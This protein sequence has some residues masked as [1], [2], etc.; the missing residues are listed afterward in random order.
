VQLHV[1]RLL[2][3]ARETG[4][5]EEAAVHDVAPV[6]L[7]ELARVEEVN[8][9]RAA[10]LARRRDR[11]RRTGDRRRRRGDGSG[12]RLADCLHGVCSFLGQRLR[13]GGREVLVPVPRGDQLPH[14]VLDRQ[15]AHAHPGLAQPHHLAPNLARMRHHPFD[16]KAAVSLEDLNPQACTRRQ[17]AACA[18]EHAGEGDVGRVPWVSVRLSALPELHLDPSWTAGADSVGHV[19][20]YLRQVQ[21]TTTIRHHG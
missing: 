12:R 8:R 21:R 15:K 3:A 13:L 19:P 7:Q 9:E 18:Y 4:R 20:S 1:H 10:A 16:H 14:Q 5:D 17:R 2:E 11:L 6:D